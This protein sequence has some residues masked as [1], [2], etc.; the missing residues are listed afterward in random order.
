MKRGPVVVVECV[1]NIPC[2]PCAAACP[3]G[4][5]RI[6]G[7]INETPSVDF[8]ACNGCGLCVSACPGLAIFVVD[9]S[10][11]GDTATVML[12]YEYAPLPEVGEEVTTLD[13]SGG[14]VGRARVTRV[15][16]TE[17]MD[18]TPVVSLEVPRDQV[19]DVR[20]FARRSR[21]P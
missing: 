8:E 14:K 16:N 2:N 15:L 5:I 7:D 12:P 6:E 18:R 10:G 19:M 3:R 9:A 21:R 20:H 1:E 4:A 13:R 17:A 11:K